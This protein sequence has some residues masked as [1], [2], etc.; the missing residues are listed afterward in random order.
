MLINWKSLKKN[1]LIKEQPLSL[2]WIS[3][4]LI[5]VKIKEL[6]SDEAERILKNIQKNIHGQSH[7][8]LRVLKVAVSILIILGCSWFYLPEF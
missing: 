8:Y 3:S 5:L 2:Q 1:I 4:L 7:R 6:E